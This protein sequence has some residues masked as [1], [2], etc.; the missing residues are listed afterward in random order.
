MKHEVYEGVKHRTPSLSRRCLQG[1]GDKTAHEWGEGEAE[2]IGK[3][4]RKGEMVGAMSEME[5][6]S[7]DKH[8]CRQHEKIS[9]C[10][11]VCG[12]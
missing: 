6:A 4:A 11:K 5:R 3:N 2:P 7:Q 10:W 8:T 12:W 9:L 1:Q